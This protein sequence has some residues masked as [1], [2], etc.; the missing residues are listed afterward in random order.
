M[1][2]RILLG[3]LDPPLLFPITLGMESDTTCADPRSGSLFG[4]MAQES[5]ITALVHHRPQ[6][7]A[8]VEHVLHHEQS[9]RAVVDQLLRCNPPVCA[10]GDHVPPKSKNEQVKK[11][12]ELDAART[13]CE[14]F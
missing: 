5:P 11:T 9:I 13:H 2:H 12:P 4:R 6:V 10:V 8:V 7:C 14:I 3:V 1:F